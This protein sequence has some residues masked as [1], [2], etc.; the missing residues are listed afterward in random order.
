M[1]LLAFSVMVPPVHAAAAWPAAATAAC[2]PQAAHRHGV[3][4][5]LLAAILHV[6]SGFRPQVVRR[7]ANGTH[8]V[9]MAQ[10]NSIHFPEL[11]RHGISPQHLFDPCIASHVAA[12]HL[13]RQ[14]K[15][16]GHTWRGLATYHSATPC[17]N[18]RYAL[19]VWNTLVAW[20]AVEGGRVSVPSAPACA[21]EPAAAFASRIGT[22]R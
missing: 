8:D 12:W 10:I 6:E 2:V 5:W 1:S 16:Q 14:L 22:V 18:Q 19:R 13:A 11:A 4:P 15:A 7:N 9:G 21:T 3:D 17:H 20:G